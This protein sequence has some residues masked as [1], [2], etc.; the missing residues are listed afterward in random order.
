MRRA[1][2]RGRGEGGDH[3]TGET[4]GRG[5]SQNTLGG[6]GG[7]AEGLPS[8]SA[9]SLQTGDKLGDRGDAGPKLFG[10]GAGRGRGGRKG[11]GARTRRGDRFGCCICFVSMK[12]RELSG[13]VIDLFSR[14]RASAQREIE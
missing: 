13:K 6:S 8:R 3:R 9:Q 10:G 1:N 5:D 4:G 14:H 2:Y 12:F 7:A 11:R